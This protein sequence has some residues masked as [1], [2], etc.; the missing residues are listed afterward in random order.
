MRDF[1]LAPADNGRRT[2]KC[3]R[4]RP[5]KIPLTTV[6]SVYVIATARFE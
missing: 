6:S 3:G 2:A 1:E 5:P 4:W